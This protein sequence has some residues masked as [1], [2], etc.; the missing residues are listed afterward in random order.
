[1]EVRITPSTIPG[2]S[3]LV[4]T[5]ASDSAWTNAANW[6]GGQAPKAGDALVFPSGAAR[7]VSSNNFPAGTQFQ[8]ITISGAGYTLGGNPLT[9]SDSLNSTYHSGSSLNAI[10]MTLG[11]GSVVVA[12]GGTLDLSGVLSGAGGLNLS[13]GGNLSLTGSV[14][15]AYSGTTVVAS[16]TL[17]LAKQGVPAIPGDL[18]IGDGSGTDL[19]RALGDDQIA[20][21]STLTINSTGL[22]DLNGYSDAIGGLNMT[23]GSVATGTGTLTLGGD[24][25]INAGG[26]TATIS[27][28]LDLGG[29]RFV[30][31]ADD[32]GTAINLDLTADVVGA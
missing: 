19:V 10:D 17:V 14:A 7:L 2:P 11:G 15:N 4:W 25:M 31:V 13:G 23:G 16:G 5:G 27:G 26:G 9:L 8:A 29:L 28:Q 3:A 22:L 18:T 24:V 21:V 20:D 32:P 6:S 1:M 30:Y 12:P